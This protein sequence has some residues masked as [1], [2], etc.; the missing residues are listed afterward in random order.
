ML[1]S[2]FFFSQLRNILRRF[3]WFSLPD[4]SR[5]ENTRD[6]EEAKTK[7][8]LKV[9]Q[10]RLS[11]THTT[12]FWPSPDTGRRPLLQVRHFG[13]WEMEQGIVKIGNKYWINWQT[14]SL[15]SGQCGDWHKW[16]SEFEW[17]V[18]L[19]LNHKKLP[20][21]GE[22]LKLN[23]KFYLLAALEPEIVPLHPVWGISREA[24]GPRL[25]V[26]KPLVRGRYPAQK[27]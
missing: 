26:E 27:K 21:I 25:W 24:Q 6:S 7:C 13:Q 23:H 8:W 9:H 4:S 14:V 22:K 5:S 10:N 1:Y 12:Q 2:A 18:E 20:G 11:Q 3:I 15:D 17:Q 19:N 16:L